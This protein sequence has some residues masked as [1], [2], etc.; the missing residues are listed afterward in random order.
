MTPNLSTR[1]WAEGLGTAFLLIGVV[2]SGIMA[3]DLSA[4]N[5]GVALLANAIATGAMLYMLITTLGPVSGAH[6]NPVVTM[7]FALRGEHKPTEVAPYI[8][9]QIIGGILGVFISHLMF[10]LDVLQLSTTSRTGTSQ[11]IA[12]IVATFGLLFTI[13]GGLKHRPDT[14]PTLVALYITGAYWF[15]ASTS[16]DHRPQPDQHFCRHQSRAYA[17][18]Y[19][20]ANHRRSVDGFWRREALQ[21]L[22]SKQKKTPGCCCSHLRG[23]LG[24]NVSRLGKHCSMGYLVW[25]LSV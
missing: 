6:F 3:E 15:T 23:F 19:C 17:D 24:P 9:V 25:P 8:V 18:V 14:V 2:G 4:G 1:L 22:N 16:F 13:L 7:A 5:T 12:E 20:R 10:D 11:W 21:T